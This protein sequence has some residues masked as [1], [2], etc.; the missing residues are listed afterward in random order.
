M[1][2]SCLFEEKKPGSCIFNK[3]L[4]TPKFAKI[5]ENKLFFFPLHFYIF[6]TE[7]EKKLRQKTKLKTGMKKKLLQSYILC[8]DSQLVKM[9]AS[10]Y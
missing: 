5:S 8:L 4:F 7:P 3:T 1:N 10:S 2:Y 9:N 6:D